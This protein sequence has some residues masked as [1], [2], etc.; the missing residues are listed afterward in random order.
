[1]S[2]RGCPGSPFSPGRAAAALPLVACL[3]ATGGP[4]AA[5]PPDVIDCAAI[6]KDADE[7]ALVKRFGRAAVKTVDLD[8][9]EGQTDRGTAVNAADPA[10]RL[11]VFWTDTTRRRR[12]A[13]VAIRNRSG[14][15]VRLANGATLGL[16]A[17][18]A[19]V[20]AANGRPFAVSGF[21]WDY[22]GY[23]KDWRGGALPNLPGGCTLTVRFDPDPKAPPKAAERASGEK[24]F[25][26]TSPALRAVKP[27]VSALTLDWGG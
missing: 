5:A 1:M 10:R 24:D 7:V 6:P 8:G 9:A 11:D 13:S 25:P 22:G 2:P 23:A 19:E 14:W 16:G 27:R 17:S 12:P 20:E 18:L 4:S 26:S 21:F 3:T 15:R